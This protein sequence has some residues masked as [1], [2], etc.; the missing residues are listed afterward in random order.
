MDH[1]FRTMGTVVSLRI[2]GADPG[3]D[4][5]ADVEARFT[6][7]DTEFSRYRPDSPASRIAD[8]RLPL[9]RASAEHKHWYAEAVRWRNAT[10][11]AFDP[12][13]R[14]GTVDLAGIVKAAAIEA[15]GAVLVG[16]DIERWCCNAGGD[17]L[18][19]GG[20][21]AT[22]WR[23]G[24]SHPDDP[25]RLL[26]TVALDGSA[27]A[28]ATSGTSHRGE[29]VWRTDATSEYRQV[30][31]IG[32]DLVEVDVLATAV[33]AGGRSVLLEAVERWDV[34]VV[35]VTTSGDLVEARRTPP[36]VSGRLNGRAPAG[37]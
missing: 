2:D 30:T 32:S 21:P 22:P 10:A 24:I 14:D 27:R 9:T 12:H 16:A 15:A 4:V 17:V 37:S 36:L 7:F 6:A 18:T 33:L 34:R 5:L 1:V 31:V 13:R 11:G 19:A 23:V 35:A 3:S 28:V 29:H 26:T 8:G 25:A 20:S